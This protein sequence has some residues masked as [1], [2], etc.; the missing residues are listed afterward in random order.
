[1]MLMLQIAM[2][3]VRG[4]MSCE[5][6]LDLRRRVRRG[7]G[8]RSLSCESRCALPSKALGQGVKEKNACFEDVKYT[9]FGL[10]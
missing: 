3:P 7:R 8:R 1:M 10:W 4:G 2:M 9:G 6:V 5:F